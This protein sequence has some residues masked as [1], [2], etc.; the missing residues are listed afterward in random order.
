MP[1]DEAS[2]WTD[3]SSWTSH[4]NL[5]PKAKILDSSFDLDV[6]CQSKVAAAVGADVVSKG[7][8]VETVTVATTKIKLS[9][10]TKTSVSTT[11]KVTFSG[12]F[13]CG[14][15]TTAGVGKAAL[16]GAA[17]TSTTTGV[18][19]PTGCLSDSMAKNMVDAFGVMLGRE[20]KK[21]VAEK[22]E[23]LLAEE[24]M[25]MSTSVNSLRGDSV[26]FDLGV[27]VKGC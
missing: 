14:V 5:V 24:F 16:V 19:V 20:D 23:G 9:V 21:A 15:S 7:G 17:A 3:S 26:S 12:V 4:S 18:A 8:Q 11:T 10:V 13:N 6:L 1:T 2:E 25:G 27:S 22:A